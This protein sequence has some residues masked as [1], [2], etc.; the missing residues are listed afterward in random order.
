MKLEALPG[1]KR[2]KR[3][4]LRQWAKPRAATCVN[5][6]MGGETILHVYGNLFIQE[7]KRDGVPMIAG[8]CPGCAIKLGAFPTPEEIQHWKT[9]LQ[10]ATP[11]EV[12]DGER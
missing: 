5:C 10:A 2:K 8:L 7:V 1:Y 3:K 11:Q 6:G 9:A 4:I 12:R